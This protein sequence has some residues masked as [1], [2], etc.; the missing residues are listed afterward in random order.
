MLIGLN[1]LAIVTNLL[2]APRGTVFPWMLAVLM[3][4]QFQEGPTVL[5]ALVVVGWLLVV[6]RNVIATPR[7]EP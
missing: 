4:F 3:F 7:T 6:A 2:T 1:L 5:G